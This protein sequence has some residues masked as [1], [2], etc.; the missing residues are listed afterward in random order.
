M[1][2]RIEEIK[3]R[4]DRVVKSI[5]VLID[6]LPD[7]GELTLLEGKVGFIRGFSDYDFSIVEK[8]SLIIKEGEETKE[9]NPLRSKLLGALDATGINDAA[10][11]YSNSNNLKPEDHIKWIPHS[12]N[13]VVN[14]L[15]E[16]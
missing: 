12:L 16:L 4:Y 13:R 5:N 10:E 3:A 11:A 9:I 15:M 7:G 6:N 1:T 14:A 8:R 2:T